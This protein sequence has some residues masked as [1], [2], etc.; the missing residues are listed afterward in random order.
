MRVGGGDIEA[1]SYNI[2]LAKNRVLPAPE[3]PHIMAV[4]GCMIGSSVC[5]HMFVSLYKVRA[6]L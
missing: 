6:L 2:L 1:I 5:S 3:G 4:P